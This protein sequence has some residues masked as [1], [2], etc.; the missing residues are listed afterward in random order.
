[1]VEDFLH[2]RGGDDGCRHADARPEAEQVA[3]QVEDKGIGSR[4]TGTFYWTFA[5]SWNAQ[6]GARYEYFNGER[7]GSMTI[8]GV[9]AMLGVT[10]K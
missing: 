2:E 1:M 7:A 6:H 3:E 10:F 9:F 5:R 8:A 4:R